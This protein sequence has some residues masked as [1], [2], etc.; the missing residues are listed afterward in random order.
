MS[1]KGPLIPGP[2][3]DAL[4]DEINNVTQGEFYVVEEWQNLPDSPDAND[5]AL[6]D[7]VAGTFLAEYRGSK[8][9]LI[10][11][12]GQV[13]TLPV[14]KD[15]SFNRDFLDL[16]VN[17]NYISLGASSQQLIYDIG[18]NDNN[19]SEWAAWEAKMRVANALYI[20]Q[21]VDSDG[22][23]AANGDL[24][25]VVEQKYETVFSVGFS[26]KAG[27][28]LNFR[29]K[30]DETSNRSIHTWYNDSGTESGQVFEE[31]EWD[32][33]GT[34]TGQLSVANN[35]V[36]M[37]SQTGAHSEANQQHH[38]KA[39]K[40]NTSS[41]WPSHRLAGYCFFSQNMSDAQ[42]MKQSVSVRS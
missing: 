10:S 27:A 31:G 35:V 36:G 34:V 9:W 6:F 1:L 39:F 17:G 18:A 32:H 40:N 15:G 20:E 12:L 11:T 28:H 5:L 25:M 13:Q 7:S 24:D 14:S 19:T 26:S 2:G 3:G 37:D 21:T 22:Y 33:S 29:H 16:D 38:T 4:S 8:W 41:T 23:S 30:K 42:T